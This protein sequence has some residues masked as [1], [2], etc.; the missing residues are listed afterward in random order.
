MKGNKKTFIISG[1]ELCS[2]NLG[3]MQRY[4]YEIVIRLDKLISDYTKIIDIEICYPEGQI[5]QLPPLKNIRLVPLKKGRKRWR[6]QILKEYVKSKNGIFIGM[7]NNPIFNKNSIVCIHDIR[8]IV[9]KEFDS[10]KIRLKFM[11]KAISAKFLASNIVTVSEREKNLIHERLSIKKDKIKVIHPGWEHM[12]SRGYD[13]NIFSKYPQIKKGSYFHSIS[14]IALNKNYKW[15]LEVAK[16]NKSETFVIAGGEHIRK[17]DEECKNYN[18][19]NVIFVGYVSDEENKSLLKHCKAL[20]HPS[21]Y[22]GFGIPP[23]EA[24]SQNKSAIVSDKSV[25]PEIYGKSVHYIDPDNYDVNLN[26][27]LDETIDPSEIERVLLKYSWDTSAEQWFEL[28]KS[29][30]I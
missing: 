25:L 3:G 6:S 30:K 10:F 28:L 27:I 7:C 26:E 24:L 9:K 4:L 19:D 29:Y 13:D 12:K 22:E 5:I 21:K 1:S 17:W 8:P 20:I 16:R 14:S 18:L 23:L 15:I 11:V 2:A